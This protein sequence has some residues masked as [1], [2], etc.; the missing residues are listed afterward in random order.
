M[1][2]QYSRSLLRCAL[3]T[4]LSIAISYGINS[5]AA[6]FASAPQ[7]PSSHEVQFVTLTVLSTCA[8]AQVRLSGG[9]DVK[10]P[11]SNSYPRGQVVLLEVLD[12]VAPACNALPVVTSFNRLVVNNKPLPEGQKTFELTLDRD[13]AVLIQYGADARP[14][15]T[16]SVLSSCTHENGLI[17]VR[18]KENFVG[19]Q[20]GVFRTHFDATFYKGQSVELEADH[21]QP[22][23]GSLGIYFYFLRWS[24]GGKVYPEGERTIDVSLDQHTTAIAHYGH[25]ITPPLRLNSFQLFRKGKPAAFIRQGDK[26]KVY[27]VILN[28]DALPAGSRVYVDSTEAEII[29]FA[30]D[31]IEARLVGGRVKIKG[32]I[33]VH[34]RVSAERY[35]NPAAFEVREE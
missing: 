13:T 23:C 32:P 30:P 19:G 33:F 14:L 28:G 22:A 2:K 25:L 3:F 29:S 9:E 18:I 17:N 35:A 27:T 5:A 26:L 34:V 12:S 11:F 16:L 24:V 31:R 7:S 10:T 8:S 1:S 6:S 15:A 4:A 21:I 20:E